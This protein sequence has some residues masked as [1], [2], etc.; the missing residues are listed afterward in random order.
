MK[1]T[2]CYKKML[3]TILS[4]T[5]RYYI[6]AHLAKDCKL[7]PHIVNKIVSSLAKENLVKYYF[8]KKIM[9]IDVNPLFDFNMVGNNFRNTDVHAF[10]GLLDFSRVDGYIK[11]R[12]K[13]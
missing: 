11:K 1:G 8:S 13:L 9:I 2:Q 12:H 5:Q 7:N 6:L 10:I 3:D 4:S